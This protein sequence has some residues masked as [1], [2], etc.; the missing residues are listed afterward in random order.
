MG[1]FGCKMKVWRLQQ[2]EKREN[3]NSLGPPPLKGGGKGISGE[4]PSAMYTGEN[5]NRGRFSDFDFQVF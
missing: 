3:R 4:S 1:H 2:V 5:M